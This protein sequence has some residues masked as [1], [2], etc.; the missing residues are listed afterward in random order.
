[1]ELT[2]VPAF[3]RNY[4]TEEEVKQAWADERDFRIC[5][6]GSPWSGAYI[7][8][9]QTKVGDKITVK[10]N[11]LQESIVIDGGVPEIK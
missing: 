1:M 5:D 3:G 8:R 6:K 4:K 9:Q 2:V 7:N 11:M 10:F